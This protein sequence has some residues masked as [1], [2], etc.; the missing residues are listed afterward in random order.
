MVTVVRTGPARRDPSGAAIT[1]D[2][3][4][5]LESPQKLVVNGRRSRTGIR[6]DAARRIPLGVVPL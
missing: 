4:D 2:P 6:R 5:K 1:L 3:S